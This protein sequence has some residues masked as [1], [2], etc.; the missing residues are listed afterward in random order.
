MLLQRARAASGRRRGKGERRGV[1]ECRSAKARADGE[2]RTRGAARCGL[3]CFAGLTGAAVLASKPRLRGAL[4]F[5]R[6]AS[7]KSRAGLAHNNHDPSG[8]NNR[9]VGCGAAWGARASARALRS[10]AQQAPSC[11]AGC[12]W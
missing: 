4:L 5:W 6:D 12:A 7:S 3:A 2:T 11:R 1:R 8:Q 9:R 10:E